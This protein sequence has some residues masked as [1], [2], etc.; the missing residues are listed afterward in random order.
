LIKIANKKE[1]EKYLESKIDNIGAY[2]VVLHN[3]VIELLW[4][5]Q[6]KNWNEDG[7]NWYLEAPC[8]MNRESIFLEPGKIYC[9]N[10]KDG[11]GYEI[12]S[13]Q[14]SPFLPENIEIEF[15]TDKEELAIDWLLKHKYVEWNN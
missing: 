8:Y 6:Y 9:S 2:F 13:P 12:D 11:F 3:N 1:L 7:S 5:T 10:T 15:L 4:F 14:V